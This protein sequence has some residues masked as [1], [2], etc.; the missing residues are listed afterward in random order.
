M[1]ALVIV[2]LAVIG[3][4]V[5]ALLDLLAYAQGWSGIVLFCTPAGL[6]VGLVAGVLVARTLPSRRRRRP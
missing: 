1:R 4:G 2:A 3:A 5:G 6:L